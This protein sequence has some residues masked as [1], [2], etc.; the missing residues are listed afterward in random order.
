LAALHPVTNG[1]LQAAGLKAII[2]G[3]YFSELTAAARE[4]PAGS[5]A[6]PSV[7]PW[8]PGG[9]AY[10]LNV[11]RKEIKKQEVPVTGPPAPHSVPRSTP[12]STA[13]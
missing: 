11:T 10:Q 13:S 5:V 7:L 4:V 12:G 1:C 3:T 9:G 6:A 2:E 8:V